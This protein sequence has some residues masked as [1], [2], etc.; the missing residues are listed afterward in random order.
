MNPLEHGR[1]IKKTGAEIHHQSPALRLDLTQSAPIVTSD[2]ISGIS[3]VLILTAFA[4]RF[5]TGKNAIE[6][7]G[8][9]ERAMNM[10]ANDVGFSTFINRQLELIVEE[11]RKHGK[12]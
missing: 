3:R 2:L 6:Q 4:Q 12:N 10:F 7:A 11:I 8:W 1:V 5:G 9:K